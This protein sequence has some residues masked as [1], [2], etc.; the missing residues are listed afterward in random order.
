MNWKKPIRD[1][2]VSI[3]AGRSIEE[4]KNDIYKKL[5]EVIKGVTGEV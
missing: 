5:E 2:I 1:R 3:D 4:I